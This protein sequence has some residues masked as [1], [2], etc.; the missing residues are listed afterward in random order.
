[1]AKQIQ[2]EKKKWHVEPGLFLE[3][4]KPLAAIGE[5]NVP[6]YLHSVRIGKDMTGGRHRKYKDEETAV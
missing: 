5:N 6:V 4:P 1:M 3:C 2:T